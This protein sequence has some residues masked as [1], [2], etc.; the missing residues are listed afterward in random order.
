MNRYSFYAFAL[1]NLILLKVLYCQNS[2]AM[3]KRFSIEDGLSHLNVY[4]IIEDQYGFI[5]IATEDGLN[6]FDGY[7]FTIYRNEKDNPNSLT[8]DFTTQLL[9]DSEGNIW[10]GTINGLNRLNPKTLEITRFEHNPG[11][12]N[13]I[14]D[15]YVYSMFEDD[16]KRI[17]IGTK[18]GISIYQP[19][20]DNFLSLK[21]DPEK[22]R[23]FPG[24]SVRDIIQ[25][26]EGNIWMATNNGIVKTSDGGMSFFHYTTGSNQGLDLSHNEARSLHIDARNQL[27]IG[28]VNGGVDMFDLQ[29]NIKTHFNDGNSSQINF[30]TSIVNHIFE[31]QPG[32][33]WFVTDKGLVN[34]QP[35]RTF[36]HYKH[37]PGDN[38][39]LSSDFLRKAI[40]DSNNNLW[41]GS[42][43][44]G[45]SLL[46]SNNQF[47]HY[48]HIPG[49]ASSLSG[50][51]ASVFAESPDGLLAIGTDG[52]GLNF[53]HEESDGFTHLM[54]KENHQ[55]GLSS[56]KIYALE[57]DGNDK[58]WTG[59]WAGGL[60][61]LDLKTNKVMHYKH[62]PSDSNSLPS[63][64]IYDVFQDSQDNIWVATWM[65]GLC[66]FNPLTNDFT[67]FQGHW[68][69]EHAVEVSTVDQITEDA[70]GNLWMI[71]VTDGLIRFNYDEDKVDQY[72][73]L[74]ESGNITTLN[75][76]LKDAKDRI[77]IATDS[78]GLAQFDKKKGKFIYFNEEEGLNG[79]S[80]KSLEEDD[81]GF[82]W[83]STNRGLSRFDPEQKHFENHTIDDG[84]HINFYLL[85]NSLKLSSG[86][87]LFGSTNGFIRFFPDQ[88]TAQRNY[89]SLYFTD[90]K[91][92]EG[93]NSAKEVE[94]NSGFPIIKEAINLDYDQNFFSIE[95]VGLS[96]VD[97]KKNQYQYRMVGVQDEWTNAGTKRIAEYTNLDPGE[98]DFEVMVSNSDGVWNPNKKSLKII[99]E[100]AFW[101]TI[102]AYILYVIALGGIIVLIFYWR[103]YEM[104]KRR[105][106]LTKQVKAKEKELRETHNHL[107][108]AEK[109]ASLGVLAAGVG[110]EINNPLNYIKM[111][112]DNIQE[113][114]KEVPK[115]NSDVINSC[116]EIMGQGVS[117]VAKIVKSLSH[118]SRVGEDQ[119]EEC[120]ISKII[121]NCLEI[122]SSKSKNV[123]VVKKYED[124]TTIILGNEGKLHQ[125]FLNIISNGLQAMDYKGNLRIS[126]YIENSNL[127]TSIKDDGEGI[128]EEHLDKIGDLFYTTKPPGQ[129]TGLGLFI[130]YSIV[131]E[132]K[133]TVEV[134]SQP[135]AGAEFIVKL[136]TSK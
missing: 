31:M 13:S 6:A 55:T 53:Y 37:H 130:T 98:Y 44:G 45:I 101:D 114:L 122:L 47:K 103:T 113:E 77:W 136:P 72:P 1:L 109:M 73:V 41:V 15:P 26:K 121:E 80:V 79:S 61:C 111:G 89:P 8:N 38:T 16:K 64:G 97:T 81:D 48:K 9:E 94:V 115:I 87:L 23:L 56:N 69:T 93:S 22:D 82:I 133:G 39:S 85:R 24:K 129:G 127:V 3:F 43:F 20:S 76:I 70:E 14:V 74:D 118:F 40:V 10:V 49:D 11:D 117:R 126:A 52:D 12:P 66:K 75:D 19:E 108:H 91:L 21:S 5:W 78:W 135:G 25:D 86:E 83:M 30:H 120:D 123:T 95:F 107:V 63:N 17:W 68:K 67:S 124:N 51:F 34:Y 131:K 35:D 92:L 112:L 33:V 54:H 65:S 102:W 116:I 29:T 125:A 4:D 62:D 96:Y 42:L 132:H 60:N 88:M 27:W 99:I 28:F 2:S 71:S 104:H 119:T 18:N 110:H 105:I 50:R 106:Q 32:E 84:L 46:T 58:L 128:D 90:F 36:K 59:T 100:P 7:S 57:F 134:I